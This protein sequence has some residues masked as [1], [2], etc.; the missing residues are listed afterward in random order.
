MACASC[1]V[2]AAR[3]SGL[4]SECGWRHGSWQAVAAGTDATEQATSSAGSRLTH[5]HH[6]LTAPA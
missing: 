6:H 2:A 1:V 3:C 5:H 4:R